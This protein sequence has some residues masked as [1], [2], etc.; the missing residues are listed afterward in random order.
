MG[1]ILFLNED[2]KPCAWP[3][4]STM[5]GINKD[6][7]VMMTCG[8]SKALPAESPSHTNDWEQVLMW[9]ENGPPDADEVD[10]VEP[11][12]DDEDE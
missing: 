3:D 11:G 10:V 7:E 9:I 8:K 5:I 4:E 1:W 6:D 12:S 2:E